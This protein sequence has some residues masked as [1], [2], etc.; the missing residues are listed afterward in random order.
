LSIDQYRLTGF[1][2]QFFHL[3]KANLG[4]SPIV[5]ADFLRRFF[6]AFSTASLNQ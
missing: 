5:F 2:A 3:S 6:G 1:A 4:D